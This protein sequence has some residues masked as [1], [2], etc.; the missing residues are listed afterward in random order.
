MIN[1]KENEI[2]R[3]AN[4]AF[5]ML[6]SIKAGYLNAAGFLATGKFVSH[7]TGFG[8]QM[9]VSIAHEDYVFGGELLI[10]PLGFILGAS[11][12][13]WYLEHQYSKDRVPK[14]FV[15]QALICLGLVAVY[16]LG[17]GGLFGEFYT[18]ADDQHD[19]II[20]GLLCF[21]CGMKNGLSTWATNGK[22]RVTHLTGLS[23]DIGM[24]LPKFFRSTEMSKFPEERHV[25]RVRILTFLSFST[26][27]LAAAF[28]FP[29]WGFQGFIFPVVLSVFVLGVT[30][31]SYLVAQSQRSQ[32]TEQPTR[33]K[34]VSGGKG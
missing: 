2:Y 28:I 19:I 29:T 31:R 34:F 25:N 20:I 17:L 10:I 30:V 27:S 21:V 3:P 15:V 8:T 12:P 24:H 5:W 16:T 18:V 22:I 26:G 11:V 13:S 33:L 9:G 1:F 7:V 23:T 32:R 4:V 6:L 14:Y